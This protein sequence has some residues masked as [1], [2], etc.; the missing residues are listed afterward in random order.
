MKCSV[1]LEDPDLNR[2][3][4]RRS[5]SKDAMYAGDGKKFFLTH[6]NEASK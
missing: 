6:T 1:N 5:Q 2:K 4:Y 3:D